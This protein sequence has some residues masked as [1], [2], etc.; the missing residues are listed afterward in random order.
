MSSS[1][2]SEQININWA[3]VVSGASLKSDNLDRQTLTDWDQERTFYQDALPNLQS[4]LY[5]APDG[6]FDDKTI[7]EY[8]KGFRYIRIHFE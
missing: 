2:L 6:D 1:D 8:E 5:S 7:A 4:T 3:A